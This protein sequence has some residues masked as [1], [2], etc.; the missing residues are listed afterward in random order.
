MGAQ[1]SG[2]EKRG[3]ETEGRG[4]LTQ[5]PQGARW[6]KQSHLNSGKQRSGIPMDGPG[7]S[8]RVEMEGRAILLKPRDWG[9]E[10]LST[11]LARTAPPPS[12]KTSPPRIKRKVEAD[13]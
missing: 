9:L 6:G 12:P 13:V 2:E 10:F 5:G 1:T 3:Q 4:T 8:G 7:G 11:W